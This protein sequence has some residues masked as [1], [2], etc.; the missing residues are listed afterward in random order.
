MFI[1][2]FIL[3]GIM[4]LLSGNSNYQS[5]INA[6]NATQSF[7]ESGD[8]EED[9][10]TQDERL[11]KMFSLPDYLYTLKNKRNSSNINNN[12]NKEL[13]LF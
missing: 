6:L 8:E 2:I 5:F 4:S 7:G 9:D 11:E 12:N 13:I 10:L 3:L 1:L